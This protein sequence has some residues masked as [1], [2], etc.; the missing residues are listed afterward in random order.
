MSRP[1]PLPTVLLAAALLFLAAALFSPLAAQED[2]P[3]V[4]VLTSGETVKAMQ[5]PTVQGKLALV[6]LWPEGE[7]STVPAAK[8]DWQATEK[9]NAGPKPTPTIS[10]WDRANMAG[11]ESLKG[12]AKATNVNDDKATS[13]HADYGKIKGADGTEV[14][15]QSD[16]TG[17]S[18]DSV[19]K[20]V[21]LTNLVVD[22][23]CDATLTFRNVSSW[24]VKKIKVFLEVPLHR[25]DGEVE[26]IR[27]TMHSLPDLMPGH[28]ANLRIAVSCYGPV[29]ERVR[30]KDVTG[31][32]A[33][34][35]AA[36]E[37]Q[38]WP[39]GVPT[40]G[41]TKAAPRPTAAPSSGKK[42]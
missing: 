37:V 19:L 11:E 20:H 2:H 36:G 5:K 31:S 35:Y 9:A 7:R 12:V 38:A 42:G 21:Q 24:R 17:L 16:A 33:Q 34:A 8:I 10:S 29:D 1:R 18:A 32:L 14:V 15:V 25:H 27:P 28:E 40:P 23:W 13:K 39:E 41:P 22:R 6:L 4:V 3:Y 30:V 26:L